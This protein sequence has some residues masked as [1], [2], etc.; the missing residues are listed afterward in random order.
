[1]FVDETGGLLVFAVLYGIFIRLIPFS[2][3]PLLFRLSL[4]TNLM[5]NSLGQFYTALSRARR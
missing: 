5:T 2:T 4:G 1:M 3:Q